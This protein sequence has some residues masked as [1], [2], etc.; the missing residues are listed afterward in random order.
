MDNKKIEYQRVANCNFYAMH[1]NCRSWCNLSESLDR[2][3]DCRRKAPRRLRAARDHTNSPAK[4]KKVAPESTGTSPKS[5]IIKQNKYFHR[6][7]LV[8]SKRRNT[9][10]DDQNLSDSKP[11]SRNSSGQLEAHRVLGYSII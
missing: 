8:N 1:S 3:E 11:D 6:A 5:V 7:P 4:E 9:S 2:E 10:T